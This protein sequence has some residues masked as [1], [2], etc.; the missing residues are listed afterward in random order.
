MS[1]ENSNFQDNHSLSSFRKSNSSKIDG[2]YEITHIPE[3]DKTFV[4]SLPLLNPYHAYA[5]PKYCISRSV[6]TLISSS[7]TH[8]KEY[9]Q[10]SKFDQHL[11]PATEQEQLVTL[12]LPSHLPKIW[13]SEGYTHL[14]FGAIRFTLTTHGREGLTTVA[15]LALLDTRYADYQHACIGTVETTL[16]AGTILVIMF[17]NFNMPIAD[18]QLLS[19]LKFQIQIVGTVPTGIT[20]YTN[21][22]CNPS[23]QDDHSSCIYVPRQIPR[24]ELLELIP[25][26]WLI[27]YEQHHRNSKNAE[28]IQSTR[29]IQKAKLKSCSKENPLRKNLHVFLLNMLSQKLRQIFRSM[30]L[31]L[32]EKPF[33]SNLK[34]DKCTGDVCSCRKCTRGSRSTRSHKQSSQRKLQMAYEQSSPHVGLHG[35]PSGKFDYFVTYTHPPSTDER[36][37]PTGWT[38]DDDDHNQWHKKWDWDDSNTPSPVPFNMFHPPSPEEFSPLT[39]FD[40]NQSTHS[41]KVR[42]P[43]TRSPSRSVDQLSPAKKS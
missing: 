6:R 16:N 8:I 4:T 5:K 15:R 36:I 27:L 1:S 24:N 26:T 39:S 2:L 33:M 29:E 32:R 18:P 40:K 30:L 43:T 12:E 19:A 10:S 7:K 13:L 41:W 42:N 20:S 23:L 28:P 25:D 22:W 11:L 38:D 31:I 34:M 14:Y 35:E 3:T 37:I 9:V 17:P 21:C